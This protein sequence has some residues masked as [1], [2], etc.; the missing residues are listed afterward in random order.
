VTGS[1]SPDRFLAAVVPVEADDLPAPARAL[2]DHRRTMTEVLAEHFGCEV[3]LRVLEASTDEAQG[4]Y[5]RRIVLV[6]RE[7][8]RVVE[9]GWLTV[10]LDALPPRAAEELVAGEAPFGRHL[11]TLATGY[12]VEPAGWFRA[13]A[14][15]EVAE[16]L[17]VRP[18]A[19]TV[20]RHGRILAAADGRVLARVVEVLAPLEALR[21]PA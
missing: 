12:R 17:G 6:T 8:R 10:E 4:L 3:D 18:G 7:G 11:R 15:G 16:A 13:E 2:L 5:R 9:H 20:G 19:E 14:Q 21:P 1:A